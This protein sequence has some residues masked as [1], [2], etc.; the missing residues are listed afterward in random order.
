MPG[1]PLPVSGR[2]SEKLTGSVKEKRALI[3][4]SHPDLSIRRQCALLGLN[5]AAYY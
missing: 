4:P 5:R 3:D 1:K 2:F